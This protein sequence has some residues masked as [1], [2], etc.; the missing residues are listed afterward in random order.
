MERASSM[1]P[2]RFG[3]ITP[4]R[5]HMEPFR[6]DVPPPGSVHEGLGYCFDAVGAEDRSGYIY[7]KSGENL[8]A[9]RTPAG[10]SSSRGPKPSL[11]TAGFAA[12]CAASGFGQ[13]LGNRGCHMLSHFDLA[14]HRDFEV[15]DEENPERARDRWVVETVAREAGVDH[16]RVRCIH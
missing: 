7:D 3:A 1:E 10:G 2:Q 16:R 15:L 6:V 4:M 8:E 14:G 13:L 5:N 11:A 12:P 9:L